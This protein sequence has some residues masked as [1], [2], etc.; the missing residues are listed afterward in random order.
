MR[1]V[2]SVQPQASM[3]APH[4]HH[5][6]PGKLAV[7]ASIVSFVLGV[8]STVLLLTAQPRQRPLLVSRVLKQHYSLSN[9]GVGLESCPTGAE[10]RVQCSPAADA[11]VHELEDRF[12]TG[13]DLANAIA[14]PGT[15]RLQNVVQGAG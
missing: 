2:T 9:G 6:A 3:V 7:V 8:T 4:H 11:I 14:A 15:K 10:Q 5:A 12:G 1:L 13:T